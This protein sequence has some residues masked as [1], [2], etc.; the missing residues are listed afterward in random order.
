MIE[1][2]HRQDSPSGPFREHRPPAY[3]PD[4]P[5]ADLAASFQLAIIEPLAVKTAQAAEEFGAETVILAGGVAA[6]VPASRAADA[7]SRRA[8]RLRRGGQLPP[9]HLVY[10]QRGHGRRGRRVGHSPGRSRRLGSRRVSPA[11]TGPHVTRSGGIREGMAVTILDEYRAARGR[12][13]ARRGRHPARAIRSAPRN[14]LQGRDRSGDRSRPVPRKIS[15]PAACA[16]SAR[17]TSCSCEEGSLGA[18]L[19]SS[20]RW[21]VDPLDGTT[22]FAHGMPTFAV[23]IALEESGVPVIGVVYDPMRDEMFAARRGRGATLNGS[24]IRVFRPPRR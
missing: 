22:N 16:R 19:P 13:G 5:I 24:P 21:V 6:N 4:A 17:I 11:A 12:D 18:A 9:A 23:S 3:R 7:G 20:F 2:E 15:S 14:P 10:R 8:S 1:G